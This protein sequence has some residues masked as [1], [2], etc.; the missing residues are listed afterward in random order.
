M[1]LDKR[2]LAFCN[3]HAILGSLPLLCALDANASALVANADTAV[4]ITV[5]NGPAGLLTFTGGHC[6]YRELTPETLSAKDCDILLSFKT[7]AHFN[8]M[9]DGTVT[10][11]PKKGLLKAGFLTGPFTRL[12]DLLTRY[13]RASDAELADAAFW[14]TS[15][16]LLFHVIAHAA[17]CIANEDPI[18]RQSASYIPD[19]CILL[20]AGDEI[21]FALRAEG[22]R[23]TLSPDPYAETVTAEMRFADMKIARA[24]FDG[25]INA[26]SS[27]GDGLISIRGMIPQVDNLNRLLD[28]V[29]VY[30]Q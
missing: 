13:L 15:T 25:K 22:N 7:P 29:A 19:G 28:R 27:V 1:L 14:K 30:L 5:K 10:P 24:L 9:I 2:T 17:A 6:T 21:S 8:G 26:V 3:L 12:T 4:G 16:V 18:G 11:I 23:L 20:S